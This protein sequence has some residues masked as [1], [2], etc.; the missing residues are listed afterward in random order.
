MQV[1]RLHLSHGPSAA[2]LSAEYEPGFAV[3]YNL[4]PQGLA[5]VRSCGS[6]GERGCRIHTAASHLHTPLRARPGLRAYVYM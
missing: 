5:P 2:Q 4:S 6:L 3:Y 1:S